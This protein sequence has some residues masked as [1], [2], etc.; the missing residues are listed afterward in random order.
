MANENGAAAPQQTPKLTKEQ[1]LK[2]LQG[3][4]QFFGSFDRVPGF[5][6]GAW[7]QNLDAIAVLSNSINQYEADDAP[8]ATPGPV[9]PVQ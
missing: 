2:V 1:K 6:A 4:H 3:V 5:L 8:A 9:D 7:A